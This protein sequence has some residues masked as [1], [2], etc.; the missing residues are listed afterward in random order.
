MKK[1]LLKDIYDSIKKV[2]QHAIAEMFRN[3]IKKSD[4]PAE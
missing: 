4:Q 2:K 1:R 3:A